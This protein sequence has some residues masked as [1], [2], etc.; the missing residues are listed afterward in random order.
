MLFECIEDNS[1][2][3]HNTNVQCEKPEKPNIITCRS[4]GG[5]FVDKGRDEHGCWKG[6]QCSIIEGD[7]NYNP[8]DYS[9][10]NNNRGAN[11]RNIKRIRVRGSRGQSN[12]G[13][14]FR[15][16]LKFLRNL[17]KQKRGVNKSLKVKSNLSNSQI[18]IRRGSS[19]RE[20]LKFLRDLKKQ[21]RGLNN[22]KKRNL[23]PTFLKERNK[24]SKNITKRKTSSLAERFKKKKLF[25]SKF[26]KNRKTRGTSNARTRTF[27][28]K[29]YSSD[30][31]RFNR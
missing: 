2:Q 18:K 21:K 14:S 7:S 22:S 4:S 5:I 16:R 23:F 19:L 9:H 24:S 20:R 30:F 1:T 29:K 26:S 11:V 17:K 25:S 31:R 3:P 28:F 8:P 13:R 27:N 15:E 6:F 10:L 12:L